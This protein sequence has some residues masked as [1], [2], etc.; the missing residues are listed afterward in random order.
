MGK[1]V[2]KA[3]DNLNNLIA[4]AL[5]VS[6][7]WWWDEPA[8]LDTLPSLTSLTPTPLSLPLPLPSPSLFRAWTPATR[9]PSTTR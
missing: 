4:P 7:E 1:G 8:P 5:I 6:G 2:T 3:V 9:R